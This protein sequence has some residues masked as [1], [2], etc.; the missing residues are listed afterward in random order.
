M[1]LITGATGH[2]GNVLV[3]KLFE[4]GEEIRVLIHPRENVEPLNGLRLDVCCADIRNFGDVQRAVKGCSQV[5]HLAGLIDISPRTSRLLNDVNIRGTRNVVRACLE[6]QVD[7]LLYVSS[8]HALPEPPLGTPI[9]ES[10]DFPRS[11][12]PGAYARSKSAATAEVYAGISQGLNAVIA[13]PT[14]VIG[15]YDY[16]MSEMGRLVRYFIRNAHRPRLMYFD[17][18]Y[19][20]V[21]VRD[22]VWGL[23]AIMERGQ[24]GRGYILGGHRLSVRDMFEEIPRI[25]GCN[26]KLVHMPYLPVKTAAKFVTLYAR[27]NKTKPFFTPY[28]IDVLRSNSD[29][30]FSRACSEL[31]YRP[32][33][34]EETLKDTVDWIQRYLS[35]SVKAKPRRLRAAAGSRIEK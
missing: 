5:Y 26:P 23:Q 10:E 30:D 13:F 28:S 33:P 34:M 18:M 21:D 8:V 31:G 17:G 14:G 2:I 15:P 12:L 22:L 1:I 27:M 4:Q 32:R 19:D 6:E 35:L 16:R 9:R 29:I 20:F 25:L 7:R 24:S 3:R 11:D